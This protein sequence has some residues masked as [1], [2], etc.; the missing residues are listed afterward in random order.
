[1]I[2]D[3]VLLMLVNQAQNYCKEVKGKALSWRQ[4]PATAKTTKLMDSMDLVGLADHVQKMVEEAPRN[5]KHD[6][7][8]QESSSSEFLERQSSDEGSDLVSVRSEPTP[9]TESISPKVP[10]TTLTE[11]EGMLLLD[12]MLLVVAVQRSCASVVKFGVKDTIGRRARMEDSYCIVPN[13]IRI[14]L[15]LEC[16]EEVIPDH[17]NGL[18]GLDCGNLA[19]AASWGG[20]RDRLKALYGSN[21]QCVCDDFHM[22]TLCDGHGGSTVSNYCTGN[23]QRS[24]HQALRTHLDDTFGELLGESGVPK[25][26]PLPSKSINNKRKFESAQR[27]SFGWKGKPAEGDADMNEPSGT[28]DPVS[29]SYPCL[30]QLDRGN[31]LRPR[32]GS[33]GVDVLDVQGQHQKVGFTAKGIADAMV[34]AFDRLNGEVQRGKLGELQ[35]TTMVTALVGTWHIGVASCGDSRAV[36]CRNSTA[37]R[38]TRDHKPSLEDEQVRVGNEGGFV[39]E[40]R[41]CPR[42]NGI[43][44]MTRAIGDHSFKGITATPE[45]TVFHRNHEDEFMILASDGLWDV[46]SDVEACEVTKRCIARAEERGA[47]PELAAKVAA[48]VLMRASLNKG[49]SDNISVIVVDLRFP[50]SGNGNG[51]SNVTVTSHN[52]H[53]EAKRAKTEMDGW[54]Q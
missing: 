45:V 35:G 32:S 53:P 19:R 30:D 5:D 29:L 7:S 22:F 50:W 20:G 44:A 51:N 2:M 24:L 16:G 3:R 52:G 47:S 25:E 43:L 21:V 18:R 36:L 48:S 8:S 31:S 17:I 13:F 11:H 38:L 15:S 10:E 27:D 33:Q 41:G 6:E 42:V 54:E 28:P 40:I 46:I 37:I 12:G 1:M 39:L 49:S 23:I 4:F 26:P 34:T 14:P 9:H